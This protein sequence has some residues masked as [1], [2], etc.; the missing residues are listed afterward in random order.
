MTKSARFYTHMHSIIYE[1]K[2]RDNEERSADLFMGFAAEA[3]TEVCSVR[4]RLLFLVQH[5]FNITASL[6]IAIK[7]F[8]KHSLNK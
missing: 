6:N 4:D 3:L 8:T 1:P 7:E 5:V 2:L